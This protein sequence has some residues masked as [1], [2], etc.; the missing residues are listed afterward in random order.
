MRGTTVYAK[1][2]GM[3]VLAV[4][5][6]RSKEDYLQKYGA[7]R[8][9]FFQM[10]GEKKSVRTLLNT[11]ECAKIGKALRILLK[12][13]E[14]K[15]VKIFYHEYEKDGNKVTTTLNL[16]KWV[17]GNKSGYAFVINQKNGDNVKINVP[18]DGDTAYYLAL[19]FE[20]LSVEQSWFSSEKIEGEEP[21][22]DDTDTP[23]EVVDEADELED[24]EEVPDDFDF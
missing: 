19:L 4:T 11:V 18:I 10:E 24:L 17:K 21:A 3:E 12:S 13:K 1:S 23:D 8:L 6:K 7:V 14:A 5:R 16:E 15:S 22:N 2:T 9:R 20:H